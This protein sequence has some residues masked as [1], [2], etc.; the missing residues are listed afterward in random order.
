MTLKKIICFAFALIATGNKINAQFGPQASF[1]CGKFGVMTASN[2]TSNGVTITSYFKF[3]K[4][5]QDFQTGL[6]LQNDTTVSVGTKFA[7]I[8]NITLSSSVPG[9]LPP[10]VFQGDTIFLNKANIK[11]KGD[12]I[13]YSIKINGLM[14]GS[15]LITNYN[16]QQMTVVVLDNNYSN[17]LL[18]Q[19]QSLPIVIGGYFSSGATPPVIAFQT[20]ANTSPVNTNTVSNI[21]GPTQ[22]PIQT[23]TIKID[24]IFNIMD[25]SAIIAGHFNF[26]KAITDNKFNLKIGKSFKILPQTVL[27]YGNTIVQEGDTI[28]I[29]S[30]NINTLGSDI[31][32]IVKLTGLTPNTNFTAQQTFVI[33]AKK[34][35]FG[36]N[37]IF[38]SPN[39]CRF[40]A[41][42]NDTLYPYN[43][44]TAGYPSFTTA[45]GRITN[46]FIPGPNKVIC[47]K[48]SSN[49]YS[50]GQIVGSTP[51]NGNGN[52][53][54]TWQKQEKTSGQWLNCT[55]INNGTINYT[56]DSILASK[57]NYNE[58]KYRRIVNS[59]TYSDTS[60]S[61]LITYVKNGYAP[62]INIQPFAATNKD[63]SL[64]V[65][66][67]NA[68]SISNMILLDSIDRQ[69][70]Y[71]RK[72]LPSNIVTFINNEN[73]QNHIYNVTIKYN[74]T[75]P[76]YTSKNIYIS[77]P[78]G[79][80]NIY[81]AVKI[82]I[83]TWMIANLRTT[84]FNNGKPIKKVSNK[85]TNSKATFSWYNKDSALN[86][87]PFG[88][89]Y[90]VT[91]MNNDSLRNVCP[92]GWKVA[93]IMDWQI[94]IDTVGGK[95][96]AGNNLKSTAWWKTSDSLS[97]PYYFNATPAGG[98]IMNSLNKFE[99]SGKYNWGAW[100]GIVPD[101]LVDPPKYDRTF[102][103]ITDT[104]KAIY[105][106]PFGGKSV[107]ETQRS[108]RCV[109][110]Q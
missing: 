19:S 96:N 47:T 42:R 101:N 95:E 82:G 55:S 56:P 39:K 84:S 43:N 107:D 99:Y 81:P 105:Y 24:S 63:M 74:G 86:A 72:T 67:D 110:Y 66:A 7:L 65:L 73:H 92:S 10:T 76:S 68:S 102:F 69:N 23:N 2:I 57:L 94:L 61:I 30:T 98:Y 46:N 97:N 77:K 75:C 40:N 79:D 109:K 60:N 32:F 1:S 80:G 28:R 70:S 103:E 104:D 83:Q 41:R 34:G 88:A 52:Y 37:S 22:G 49:Y 26:Y 20:K 17:Y 54:Y 64:Q 6:N 18:S 106:M 87:L 93:D 91:V 108:I 78:D 59:G 53:S 35:K 11:S 36:D 58:V 21:I 33:I 8:P 62:K 48:V 9:G 85:I 12:S 31:P 27:I 5:M 45:L 51:N 25:S 89:L 90:N 71:V 50:I 16:Q 29:D 14:A 4:A 13:V 44:I 38:K 3:N 15:S 100:W